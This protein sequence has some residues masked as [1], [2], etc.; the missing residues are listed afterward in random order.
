MPDDPFTMA[1]EADLRYTLS[2]TDVRAGSTSGS[3]YASDMTA[4]FRLRITDTQNCTPSSCTTQYDGAGTAAEVELS[5]PVDCISTGG[6]QGSTCSAN[7]SANAVQPGA[8]RGGKRSVL[9]IFRVRVN[10]AG[11]NGVAGDTD[12]TLFAQQGVYIP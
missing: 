10:D 3:D 5:M 9:Q 11:T 1:D 8:V 4:T 2:Q 12:D 7:T 6:P